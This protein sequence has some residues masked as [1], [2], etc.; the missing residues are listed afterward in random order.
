MKLL[1]LKADGFGALRGEFRFDPDRV[2][3]ILDDNERGKS[4]LL[5][6]IAA[7]LYGLDGDRRSHRPLTPLERWKP[8]DGGS[9]R[10]E[11]ELECEGERYIVSR[12]F[13]H[14]MVSI[15]T[16]QG[17]DA[18]ADFRVGK[19]EYPVGHKLLD[20][21][22]E[23]FE[24]CAMVRQGDLLQV[25][26]SEERDR[27]TPSLRAKLE[28]VAD[29][30]V[31]DTRASEALKVLEGALRRY[32]CAELDFTGT[33]DNAIQRL[34][35]KRQLL[36][37]EL[38]ELAHDLD[39][40]SGPLEELADI[41]E[42]ER[43]AREGLA[44]LDAEW[45]SVL[46]AD[47]R[48]QLEEDQ[49]RRAEVEDLRRQAETL[50]GPAGVPAEAEREFRDVVAR[51]E[52][53]HRN[54]AALEGRRQDEMSRERAALE[55]ELA[56]L[57]SFEAGGTAEADRCVS[58]AA[59]IRRS[60]EEEAS[61]RDELFNLRESLATEGHD[62]GRL[63]WLTNR[64]GRLSEA[65]HQL[66]RRQSQLTLEHHTETAGLENQRTGSSET[67]REIDAQ[68]SQRTLPGW[69]LLAL[70]ISTLVAGVVVVSLQ[71]LPWLSITFF[72]A[73]TLALIVG[74]AMVQTGSRLRAAE[75]E[76]AVR[77]LGE[78]QRWLSKLRQQLAD[79]GT[80]LE[81]LAR[82][83]GYRDHV[84][85]MREW[86]ELTA[87][88]DESGP[89]VQAQRQLATLDARRQQATEAA[90]ELLGR[91][92]IKT[93]EPENLE[94]VAGLL[95]QLESARQKLAALDRNW[96]WIDEQ[97]R[98]DEAAAA[99]LK[100]R[101]QRILHSAGLVYDPERTWTEHLE[102][103][104]EKMQGRERWSTLTNDL[105]PSAERRLLTDAQRAE[106]ESQL[107]LA[108]GAADAGGARRSQR[109]LDVERRRLQERL[110]D[111]Q[112]RRS[113]LR[114]QVE[115]VWRRVQS[116]RPEKLA[117]LERVS[118][119]LAR[120]RRFKDAV[121]LA[122]RTI[123]EVAAET[124]QRWA[125]HL[126]RRVGE[127]LSAVGHAIEQVRFGDDL[128]FSVRLANGQSLPRG[129]AD[130]Q[131][132]AGARDQLYLAVRL[133][134]SEFLSRG[135]TALPLLLDDVFVTSDDERARAGMRLLIER[136]A[137]E[138][139]VILM[140]CHRQ[141]FERLAE[142]DRDLYLQRVQWLDTRPAGNAGRTTAER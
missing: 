85:L 103:L 70:G 38:N 137:V 130:Q 23:E 124:H 122:S 126:N 71:G 35:A 138:H 43:Q 27:R 61:L 30:R 13:D 108:E 9:Y 67:L 127:L 96:S 42:A 74:V 100:E 112:R 88:R 6:A 16:G 63:Q 72:V 89:A 107:A 68:R 22:A 21:D 29:S 105:L 2:A 111:L 129:K 45:R 93:P 40:N 57:R 121:E 55:S 87:L 102:E 123:H 28:A 3:V 80:E 52:E 92:G 17:R 109:E 128:D 133:A 32:N 118:R 120:A 75:R 101:A 19:D 110:D 15:W 90:R 86:N 31:G 18:T 41:G 132:S 47:A 1:R 58:L 83:H 56:S 76:E 34:D 91:F 4:T 53:A 139:Q 142:Q 36:E 54:L 12:D 119:A 62:P 50:A 49:R 73:G 66:L 106:L 60:A 65:D 81:A 37:T 113:D 20:L 79:T 69:F 14:G 48:R 44:G 114:V 5:A 33:A 46:A 140:T 115:E 125:D 97:K 104:T 11:L 7:A 59:E 10:V 134:V 78:A 77:M 82:E 26:P 95:R 24:R 64:L 135:Q 98:V 8:W 99:G 84:E 136:F 39:R 131:L 51:L 117:Q 116:E 94:K 25:V 141:R